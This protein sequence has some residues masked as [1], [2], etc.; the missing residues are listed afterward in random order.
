MAKEIIIHTDLLGNVLAV[1]D[2]VAM[3]INNQMVVSTIKKLHPKMIKL[4][5]SSLSH[6]TQ[7][8]HNKYGKDLIK[9]EGPRVT[10]YLIK[11]SC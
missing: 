9:L 8:Y 6:W 3:S 1:G 2:T 7:G 11:N 10:M 4:S 5:R